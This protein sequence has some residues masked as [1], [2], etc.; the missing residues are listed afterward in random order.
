MEI[1]IFEAAASRSH[2]GI[3]ERI[4]RLFNRRVPKDYGV[5]IRRMIRSGANRIIW[6]RN[7][8]RDRTMI[9]TRS[10]YAPEGDRMRVTRRTFVIRPV[11]RIC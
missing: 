6:E 8:N 4:V 10:V 7:I 11:N 9:L 1:G 3:I 5:T 2:P